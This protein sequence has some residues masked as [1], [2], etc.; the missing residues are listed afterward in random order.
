MKTWA[1]CLRRN[2]PEYSRELA[3]KATNS[4]RSHTQTGIRCI[5]SGSSQSH[6]ASS[7]S[8]ALTLSKKPIH[9]SWSTET[10]YYS[11]NGTLPPTLMPSCR[12]AQ[13]ETRS[14]I[15][16]CSSTLRQV[17]GFTQAFLAILKYSTSTCIS[18]L[19]TFWVFGIYTLNTFKSIHC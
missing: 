17:F 4:S 11:L 8:R 7:C 5:C 3:A 13:Q 9:G 12:F 10:C 1:L 19:N 15:G 18:T 6:C 14:L 2:G 16:E